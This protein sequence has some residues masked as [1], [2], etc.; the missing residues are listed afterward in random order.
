MKYDSL[1]SLRNPIGTLSK[2]PHKSNRIQSEHTK[3]L[4]SFLRLFYN[5]FILFRFEESVDGNSASFKSKEAK[6]NC[7]KCVHFGSATNGFLLFSG[8]KI[9]VVGNKF[10]VNKELTADTLKQETITLI[11][12]LTT[13]VIIHI[14]W[15]RAYIQTFY[16]F[17]H[18]LFRLSWKREIV[19]ISTE[20]QY[21][22]SYRH[23]FC[24]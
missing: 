24:N 19:G 9:M 5:G 12:L 21:R 15:R 1:I 2:N 6:Q 3:N 16:P 20:F 4:L 13:M 10:N 17:G 7:V 18:Y 11:D 23:L 14:C 8:L 22:S